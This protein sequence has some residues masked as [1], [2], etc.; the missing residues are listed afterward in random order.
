MSLSTLDYFYIQRC[1]KLAQMGL[2]LSYPNPLVGA[3]IVYNQQIIGEGYHRK[4]G[5]EHAEV[6]AI[7][8]V[9]NKELLQ[10]SSLYVNLE[11]CNHYG[12]TPPCSDAIIRHNIPRVVIDTID[13]NPLVNHAGIEK[14]RNNGVEVLINGDYKIEYE[15]LNKRFFTFHTQKRP[16]IILKWAQSEDGFLDGIE[17]QPISISSLLCKQLSHKWRTEENAILIGKNTFIKDNPRLNSRLWKGK[18]N[19]KLIIDKKLEAPQSSAIFQQNNVIV[20]NQLKS[21]WENK[22]RFVTLDFNR[23]ILPQII[24]YLYLEKIQSL[25]VEG[26][27]HTLSSFIHHDLWDEARVFTNRNLK[28]SEG[29]KAPLILA[30]TKISTSSLDTDNFLEIYWNG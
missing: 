9:R 28:I 17:T 5:S 24:D 23:D 18:D 30:K 11:P 21:G 15:Q 13:P 19:Y 8:S 7:N 20:F 29:T 10:K 26:G 14:L 3:L 16:Y 6:I 22:V 25:I 1:R 12:K 2:G 4:A 27:S